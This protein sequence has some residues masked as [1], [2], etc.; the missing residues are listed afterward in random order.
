MAALGGADAAESA[1][2]LQPTDISFYGMLGY[3]HHA[4]QFPV[5]FQFIQDF[6]RTF[7]RLSVNCCG[8]RPT[9]GRA[10]SPGT[11]H[12]GLMDERVF[13]VGAQAHG[14]SLFSWWKS[15]LPFAVNR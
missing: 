8:C 11:L 15:S 12:R 5:L 9:P 7:S 4:G 10:A 14:L 1:L 2:Y 13:G 6:L 3:N